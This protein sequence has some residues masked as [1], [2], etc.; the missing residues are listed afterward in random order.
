MPRGPGKRYPLIV[1]RHIVSRW[2]F[3]LVFMGLVMIAIAYGEYIKPMAAYN[4]LRWQA[5]A[6]V[7]ALAILVGILFFVLRFVAY[8]QPYPDYLKLV[9]PFLQMNISYKRIRRTQT[10]E[11]RMLFPMKSLSGWVQDIFAPLAT[12]T[13]LVIELTGYPISP[14]ILRLFLSRF[15]FKD[16]TPHLVILVEDWLRFSSE[17]DSMRTG[18]EPQA[19]EKRKRDSILSRLPQR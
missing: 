12:K 9:T 11:M 19:E 1:Y 13:A 3:A 15:F 14:T 5:S 10:T 7:G 17:L 16:K 4:P 8:I 18:T 6:G 2:W